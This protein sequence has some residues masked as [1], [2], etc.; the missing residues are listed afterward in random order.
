MMVKKFSIMTVL[1][2]AGLLCSS[3]ASATDRDD[4]DANGDGR[5]TFEE[6]MK[7]VEAATRKTFDALDRN[8]DGALSD[9]D[10]DGVRE[11]MKKMEEWLEELIKPFLPEE[12]GKETIT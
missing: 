4:Y 6:V 12:E 10:F 8:K 1:V 5:I 7:R 9:E 2:V 3:P 11:K